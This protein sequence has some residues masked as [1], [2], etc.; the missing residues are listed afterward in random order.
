[1]IRMRAYAFLARISA[2][3][4][5]ELAG[6]IVGSA[7]IMIVVTAL[8]SLWS[9]AAANGPL[10]GYSRT[11]L[12]WYIAL[13]EIAVVSV[14][15]QFLIDV[16]ERIR[17]GEVATLLTRPV[18]AAWYIVA[19]EFGASL[20]RVAALLPASALIAF[21]LAGPPPSPQALLTL[22]ITLPLAIALQ[23]VLTT[24]LAGATF[25]LGDSR[26]IWFLHQKVIFLLGGMLIPVELLPERAEPIVRVLPWA[27]IAY[28]PAATAVHLDT[29]TALLMVGMQ[30][31]WIGVCGCVLVGVFSLGQ[32]RMAVGGG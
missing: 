6:A 30:V 21:V 32:R 5:D 31:F 10:G 3:R 11:E 9:A 16:G 27:G 19:E 23:I 7:F 26:A 22:V 24:A 13:A 17:D 12:V 4:R 14:A 2:A 29:Q 8:G 28:T 1:M 20:T 18:S 15:S 25:W